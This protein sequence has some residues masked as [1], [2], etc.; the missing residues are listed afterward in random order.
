MSFEEYLQK[1]GVKETISLL[2]LVV[3]MLVIFILAIMFQK[4]DN[5]ICPLIAKTG[6]PLK[7]SYG[8][9]ASVTL[10]ICQYCFILFK[11]RLIPQKNVGKWTQIKLK[12][13][14]NSSVPLKSC[15]VGNEFK[16]ERIPKKLDKRFI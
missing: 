9:D 5:N 16:T 4:R 12:E 1:I 8:K 2:A 7:A 11:N 13:K 6:N 10:G 14:C 15:F 3:L